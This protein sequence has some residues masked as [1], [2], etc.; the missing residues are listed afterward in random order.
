VPR[1]SPGGILTPWRHPSRV[2]RLV[3]ATSIEPD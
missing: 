3:A 2:D 1:G